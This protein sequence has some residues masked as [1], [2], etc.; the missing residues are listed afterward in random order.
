[1]NKGKMNSLINKLSDEKFSY[2][3]NDCFTFTAALVKEWHG[4]DYRKL[5]KY[6][7]K[8]EA[9]RYINENKGI[10]RLTTGTLG[11]GVS[12]EKCGDGDV[13]IAEVAPDEIALGF[14]FDGHGLFKGKKKVMKMKL[15]NCVKG[16]R[17]S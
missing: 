9:M 13:V 15:S 16:W 10:E 14:V 7:N 11:Y 6:K 2:G 8:A 3:K 12:P 5:H 1:M 4:S 17:L